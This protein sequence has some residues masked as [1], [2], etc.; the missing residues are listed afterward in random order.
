MANIPRY[1]VGDVG[2]LIPEQV[3]ESVDPLVADRHRRREDQRRLVQATDHLQAQYGLSRARGRYD[4][5][6]IVV[7]MVF[8]FRQHPLLV[9]APRQAKLDIL[10]KR[11]HLGDPENEIPIAHGGENLHAQDAHENRSELELAG[12]VPKQDLGQQGAG[13]SA[14]QGGQV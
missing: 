12:L 4:M 6:V 2:T 3:N 11:L 13:T 10:G 7:E 9:A 5:Q 14:G 1:P 8:E